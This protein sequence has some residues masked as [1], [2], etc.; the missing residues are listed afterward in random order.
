[1]LNAPT[2]EDSTKFT[3]V[4]AGSW[5]APYVAWAAANGYVNGTSATTFDPEALITFEQMGTILANYISK[6]GVELAGYTASV[7]Y[8]DASSISQWAA[9]NMEVIRKYGLITPD[10]N[11]NVNPQKPVSR[12]DGMVSLVRLARATGLGV[13]P[14]ID[15]YYCIAPNQPVLKG[16]VT[17]YA[18]LI[19]WSPQLISSHSPDDVVVINDNI[20]YAIKNNLSSIALDGTFTFS[21]DEIKEYG[22]AYLNGITS[23][24]EM[25]YDGTLAYKRGSQFDIIFTTGVLLVASYLNIAL[26]LLS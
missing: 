10:A 12:A 14:V 23:Y 25:G 11:G 19:P 21:Q 4:V 5:Y 15:S 6:T 3:D 16:V 17:S 18:D 7:E 2:S 9:A 22:H 24:M 26:R 20:A 13:E 8:K 1:M